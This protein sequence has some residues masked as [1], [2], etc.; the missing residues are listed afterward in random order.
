MKRSGSSNPRPLYPVKRAPLPPRV[1]LEENVYVKMRDGVKV[2]VDVY[3][4]KALGRYPALLSMSPYYKELQQKHPYFSKNIEAGATDLLVPEGYVHVIAQSRGTC[5]SQGQYNFLDIKEQQDGYDLVE[6]IAEQSWS[7]GNVATYGESYFSM[8]QYPIAALKPPHLK[9]CVIYEGLTDIY[10]DFVYQGGLFRDGFMSWWGTVLLDGILWPGLGQVEG[11][12]PPVNLMYDWLSQPN[13]GP[14]Y[15]ERSG[16]TKI[17][18]I[19][20]PML[21]LSAPYGPNHSRGQLLAYQELKVPKKLVILPVTF[22]TNVLFMKSKALNE[23]I[24]RWLD[25]WLKGID[26]GIMEEPEV[27]ICDSATQEWRYEREYPLERTKWTKFYLRS[28]PAGPSTDPPY[29]LISEE[30]PSGNEAPDTYMTPESGALVRSGNPVVAFASAA[31]SHD[32]RVYGP[33]G[34]TLYGSSTSVDTAWFVR[35]GDVGPD[36][37]IRLLNHGQLKASHREVDEAKSKPGQPF[38]PHRAPA[39]LETKKVYEFQIPMYPMFHTFKAGHKIWIQIASDNPMVTI[40]TIYNQILDTSVEN[41]IYHDSEHP[42]HLLLPVI[43][44]A[45]MIKS[46][47]PPVS[48]I[49]WP[50]EGLDGTPAIGERR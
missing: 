24:R 6:W 41:A 45:P 20:V 16:V 36:G 38:H 50:P 46:V 17:D 2:A 42:S 15:W 13:D 1:Q 30:A 7:D 22:W 32:M 9:C 49:K 23:Q 39:L 19:D 28:N 14:Y 34:V 43:P 33:A 35:I 21:H 18:K 5:M 37:Q 25:Y 40:H 12:L 8:I 44:D 10:R 11:K 47:E 31:M 29:G 48:K 4:P 3:R 26:T 27:V